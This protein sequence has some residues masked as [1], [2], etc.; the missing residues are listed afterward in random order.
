MVGGGPASAFTKV[1][2][3]CGGGAYRT[4]VRYFMPP[5][6]S[7]AVRRHCCRRQAAKTLWRRL[8]FASATLWRG[9]FIL[10]PHY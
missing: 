4:Y 1:N 10:P 3:G 6:P 9:E 2:A 7:D 8:E 5:H